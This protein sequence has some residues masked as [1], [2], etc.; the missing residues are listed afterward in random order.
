VR[1]LVYV[2]L[3]AACGCHPSGLDVAV[4]AGG[5]AADA[6]PGGDD[7]DASPSGGDDMDSTARCAVALQPPDALCPTGG[8]C[9]VVVN[10]TLGCS[11]IGDVSSVA[12]GAGD[13]GFVAFARIVDPVHQ[14]LF[15]IDPAGGSGAENAPPYDNTA[16]VVTDGAGTPSLIGMKAL[17]PDE[18]GLVWFTRADTQWTVDTIASEP[19]VTPN[20]PYSSYG[21][22]VAADG[23][24]YVLYTSDYSPLS[25]ASAAAGETAFS[26]TVVSDAHFA[27]NALALDGA[28]VPYALYWIHR[29]DPRTGRDL[30]FRAGAAAAQAVYFDPNGNDLG[31]TLALAVPGA[32]G[33]GDWPVVSFNLEDAIHVQVPAGGSY[34]EQT[35]PTVTT[36]GCPD[37]R[38]VP[39]PQCVDGQKCTARGS[40]ALGTHVLARTDDG[41]VWLAWIRQDVDQ[42][43]VIERRCTPGG[44]TCQPTLTADR[45][46]AQLQLASVP[47]TG[48]A[49]LRFSA[50]L[51]NAYPRLRASARGQRIYLAIDAGIPTLDGV[52]YLVLDA[53]KL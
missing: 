4:D 10:A 44:C 16:D 5:G 52:R 36:T 11:E 32:G 30:M 41:Q 13:R 51:G 37:Y 50:P 48:P 19:H 45:S 47:T 43:L 29:P 20:G 15:T 31:T 38:G 17:S 6:S 8:A 2:V 42:D 9:P 21:E 27:D 14:M 1:A 12:A 18:D 24:R 23:R 53:T 39:H 28:G 33:A 3:L 25:L 49:A 40:G 34:V 46:S 7:A 35:I 26:S 22:A